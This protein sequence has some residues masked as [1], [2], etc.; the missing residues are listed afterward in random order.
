MGKQWEW[1]R[2]FY[3]D[4]LQTVERSQMDSRERGFFIVQNEGRFPVRTKVQV[5]NGG[6]VVLRMKSLEP[7]LTVESRLMSFHTHCFGSGAPSRTDGDTAIA[8]G[9]EYTVIGYPAINRK[10]TTVLSLPRIVVWQIT[11]KQGRFFNAKRI[12]KF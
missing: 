2:Q 8:L 12:F 3:V 1:L 4:M 5:G 11:S 6:Q 7:F 10:A 9:E